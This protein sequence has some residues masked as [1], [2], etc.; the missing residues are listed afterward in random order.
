MSHD[1]STGDDGF[2]YYYEDDTDAISVV[3][4]AFDNTSSYGG[5][6]RTAQAVSIK[7]KKEKVRD[8]QSRVRG[9]ET[10][11]KAS[12]EEQTELQAELSKV[13]PENTVMMFKSKGHDHSNGQNL[14]WEFEEDPREDQGQYTNFLN[15]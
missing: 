11:L 7:K 10:T 5:V 8:L 1:D 14:P 13:S 12:E 9:A 3:P 6:N 15:E 2:Y 4:S